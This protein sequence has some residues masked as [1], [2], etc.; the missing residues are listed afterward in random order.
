MT[1]RRSLVL[2]LGVAGFALASCAHESM[3][4]AAP[5]PPPKVAMAPPAPTPPPAA[6]VEPKACSTDSQC[7]SSQLCVQSTCTPITAALAECGVARVHFDFDRSELH[8]SDL[9]TLD[10]AARC[11]RVSGSPVLVTGDADER[12][13][14]RYNLALGTRRAEAVRSR[15]TMDGVPSSQIAI[16]TY[17]KELPVCT[18]HDEACWSQNRRA[19]IEPNGIAKDISH[20][21]RQDELAEARM[22]RATT[23]RADAKR[24]TTPS[25][26]GRRAGRSRATQAP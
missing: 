9:P 7:S 10:R 19:S 13:S 15:L 20:L 1:I 4:I 8:L 17:G 26:Q 2:G 12:G 23:A 14:V 21:I 24:T 18:E 3:A 6:A 5:P 25:A 11:L 16:A 22:R